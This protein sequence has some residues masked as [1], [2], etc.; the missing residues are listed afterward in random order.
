MTNLAQT[1]LANP[2]ADL[3]RV[4]VSCG[5]RH[6][7]HRQLRKRIARLANALA[8][9]GVRKG[10]RVSVL[11]GNCPEFLEAYYAITALGGLYVPLNTRLSPR[12]HLIL[13]GDSA[14]VAL[15]SSSTFA[16]TLKEVSNLPSLR[17]VILVDRADEAMLDYRQLVDRAS[18]DFTPVEVAPDD[19]AAIVYTSGT[20]SLPKGVVLTHGNY[21]ADWQNLATVVRPDADSVNLQIAPLYHAALCHS[22]LHLR[23]GARTI[24]LPKFDP[25]LVLRT[26]AAERVTHMFC[27]PTIIYDLLDQPGFTSTDFSSLRT[28]EYGA[29]PMTRQRL[30]EAMRTLGPVFFHAYGMTET[31]S[32]CCTISGTEH[33]EVLGS[34]GKPLPLDRMRILDEDDNELGPDEVGEMV[35]QGPNILSRYWKR[36]PET[37][38]AL[39]G[40][41]L[42]TGDLGRKD[43]QGYYWIVDR[44]KD[45]IISGGVNI[46]PKDIEEVIA[47]DP[48]V[49]EV[50]V[51]GVPHPRWGEAV[52]AA[53]RLRPGAT[54]ERDDL[55]R[56]MEHALGRFQLPKSV[57]VVDDFPRNGTGKIMKH[58]LRKQ[59]A[60]TTE[61]SA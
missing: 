44:K 51:Y 35:V 46:Y 11:L 17:S 61:R 25:V 38:A 48:A 9:L 26:V 60:E 50:A 1:V 30:D 15:I 41:W 34:I 3:D 4:A 53:V 56:R 14:P 54:L 19:D 37:A 21:L 33:N 55:Q 52:A 7:T 22:V 58:V 39:K 8:G 5:E 24:L 29:A 45:M 23:A 43:R 2:A 13:L 40:G 42:H 59:A 36:E 57:E 12:E 47:C 32:H 31:T 6:L 28:L 20:T 49:A 27:V 16:E 18:P 10:D